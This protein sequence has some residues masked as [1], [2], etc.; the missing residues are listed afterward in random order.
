LA[1]YQ[2]NSQKADREPQEAYKP[3]DKERARLWRGSSPMKLLKQPR[4]P[5]FSIF[6]ERI[7]VLETWKH[8]VDKL[9]WEIPLENDMNDNEDDLNLNI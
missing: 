9:Y 1:C 7:K 4:R 8:W 5:E 3:K 2:C 6:R